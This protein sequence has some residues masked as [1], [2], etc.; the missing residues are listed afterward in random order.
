MAIWSFA[1]TIKDVDTSKEAA[2]AARSFENDLWI[3]R[4]RAAHIVGPFLRRHG[5]LQL[6]RILLDE[7]HR[8]AGKIA[9]DEYER[10]LGVASSGSAGGGYPP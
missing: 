1:E 6:A 9:A 8:L 2:D 4:R 10:L 3:Q 7:D 5:R